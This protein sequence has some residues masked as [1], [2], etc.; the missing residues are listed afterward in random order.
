MRGERVKIQ[1]VP[2]LKA[3]FFDLRSSIVFTFSVATH[4]V[5]FLAIEGVCL[6][7]SSVFFMV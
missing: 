1:L 4:P 5:W 6:D 7:E 3:N 2:L